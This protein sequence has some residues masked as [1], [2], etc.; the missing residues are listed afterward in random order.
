MNSVALGL[1]F[2]ILLMV[3]I[4]FLTY[5]LMGSLDDFLL[6]GRRIGPFVAAFSERASGESAW[7]LLGLPGLAYATGMSAYWTVIGC[8]I[9]IFLSWTLIAPRLRRETGRY[10]AL[11]I[12]DYL[13]ARFGDQGHFLRGV[14]TFVIFLFYL[15][16][17]GAQFI[18][19]GKILEATFGLPQAWGMVIGAGVVMLYTLMGG[20][21]AVA[22]TDVVQGLIMLLVSVI[23]PIIG[24]IG[25]GGWGAFTEKLMAAGPHLLD[26]G[27]G[28]TGRDLVLGLAIGGL[29]IGLGYM[30]QPHLLARYMA[31][32]DHREV[33]KGVVVAMFWVLLAYW[34]AALIGLVGLA[35]FGPGTLADQETVMPKLA[36]AYFPGLIAGLVISGA[37]A[38][39]MSTAD[40]QLLVVTSA[41]VEDFYRKLLGREGSPRFF[42]ALS[43]WVT[44][45]VALFALILA[46]GAKQL[47]FWLVLYAWAGLGASFGPPLLLSLWWKRT[48]RQGVLAGII[49][50]TLTV[51]IWYN[52]PVL[53]GLVYELVP[54]FLFSLI[55]TWIV[56]LWTSR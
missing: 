13:E 6:G 27:G 45:G 56:S 46:F 16:Y 54:A 26:I 31:I 39:M 2:Y 7:F 32:R 48:T 3:V 28:K 12:P 5:R 18:G 33:R 38:A 40:S 36:L 42:V 51:L 11:T 25:L 30:G 47:I 53:K 9:G 50:G 52:V 8:A 34:G 17:L 23:L 24:I 1:V 35:H 10:G 41:V 43:R 15:V 44:V 22:W 19:A 20:F 55:T 37:L 4:G 49:A 14:S 21:L 29:G